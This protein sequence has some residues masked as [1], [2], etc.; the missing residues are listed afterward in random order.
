YD[1]GIVFVRD[2][3]HL[4]AAMAVNA[5]YLVI[6][7]AREP[8]HYTPDFSR[9]ARGVE[10]WAAL[11][12]LG[13]R[14]LGDLVEGPCRHG[15]GLAQGPR[16]GGAV[17]GGGGQGRHC[18]TSRSGHADRRVDRFARLAARVPSTLALASTARSSPGN[19][20]STSADRSDSMRLVPSGRIRMSPAVRSR[21]K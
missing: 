10:V 7:D 8:E 2:P 11:R 17:P 16:L 21:A 20:A 3:R 15:A 13:R 5:P 12:S 9:R 18:P 6:S 1:S 19:R 14:G 4:H